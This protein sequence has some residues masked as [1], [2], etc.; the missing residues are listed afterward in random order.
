MI[1]FV[2]LLAKYYSM[3]Q[4]DETYSASFTTGALLREETIAL[5]GLMQQVPPDEVYQRAKKEAHHLHI[6]SEVARRKIAGEILKRYRA[7]DSRLWEFFQTLTDPTE[8]SIIL[9]YVC[10]K[11]YRMLF[12]FMTTTVVPRWQQ[13]LLSLDS[14][15]FERFIDVRAVYHTELINLTESTRRKLAQITLLMMKQ[16]GLLRQNQLTTPNVSAHVWQFLADTGDDWMLDVGL[17]TRAD[18]ER[19]GL[20]FFL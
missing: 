17:L 12:D 20:V 3:L 5:L 4:Q 14:S 16:A 18:R 2:V 9:L 13:R 10:L 15:D 11:T 8:Q 1:N 7:V 19:L 6:N